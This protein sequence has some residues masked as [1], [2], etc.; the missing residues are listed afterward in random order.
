MGIGDKSTSTFIR[1]AIVCNNKSSLNRCTHRDMN[2]TLVQI[3]RNKF[4]TVVV[5]VLPHPLN[6]NMSNAQ[7]LQSPWAH[8]QSLGSRSR[9]KC[10]CSV[11]LQSC[12][13]ISQI[14]FPSS[15]NEVFLLFKF[16]VRVKIKHP[17]AMKLNAN[18]TPP[19]PPSHHAVLC[20]NLFIYPAQSVTDR[21]IGTN[22]YC[23]MRWGKGVDGNWADSNGTNE[24]RNSD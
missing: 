11:S 13:K 6:N 23:W 19:T 10:C 1:I 15:D 4:N 3:A 16:A 12:A 9:K 24:N 14:Q 17:L 20:T 22:V 5:I 8:C 21:Q 2:G 7:H 18:L